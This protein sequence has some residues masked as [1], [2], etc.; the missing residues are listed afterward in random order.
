MQLISTNDI[1]IPP[2]I[3]YI[4]KA[5]GL[6]YRPHYFYFFLYIRIMRGA[7]TNNIAIHPIK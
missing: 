1:R 7:S 6:H 3:H 5:I 4:V 2:L